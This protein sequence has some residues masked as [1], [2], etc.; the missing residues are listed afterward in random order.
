MREGLFTNA[1][2]ARLRQP[3][4]RKGRARALAPSQ[5]NRFVN[6][7]VEFDPR[8]AFCSRT[9]TGTTRP[10]CTVSTRIGSGTPS[11]ISIFAMLLRHSPMRRCRVRN[12]LS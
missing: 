11:K 2:R 8:V 9:G 10:Y 4:P 3:E 5:S 1:R 12:C 6:K 7:P